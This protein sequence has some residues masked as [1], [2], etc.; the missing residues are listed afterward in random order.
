M[1]KAYLQTRMF[2]ELYLKKC[3]HINNSY[4]INGDKTTKQFVS[5]NLSILLCKSV[6]DQ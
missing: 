6:I 1:I 4:I 2:F 3:R 5:R